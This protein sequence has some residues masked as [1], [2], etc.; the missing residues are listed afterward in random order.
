M[1]VDDGLNPV[2]SSVSGQIKSPLQCSEN[3]DVLAQLSSTL[4]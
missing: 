4:I 1:P 3:S 2:Q